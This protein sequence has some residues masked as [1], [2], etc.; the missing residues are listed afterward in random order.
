MK[1]AK[2]EKTKSKHKRS[3]KEIWRG[4]PRYGGE[5]RTLV[6]EKRLEMERRREGL[7]MEEARERKSS[8]QGS[9][10]GLRHLERNQD[11]KGGRRDN[12]CC[13]G[14]NISLSLQRSP[15]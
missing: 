3:N 1:T 6:V 13:V 7:A 11:I 4:G 10:P 2:E 15:L 8:K 5:T 14:C 9:F 12:F